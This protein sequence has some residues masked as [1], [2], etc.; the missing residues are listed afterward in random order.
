MKNPNR[1]GLFNTKRNRFVAPPAK[2]KRIF[3]RMKGTV[4]IFGDIVAS[5]GERWQADKP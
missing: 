4:E 3:G 2:R 5:T 1:K